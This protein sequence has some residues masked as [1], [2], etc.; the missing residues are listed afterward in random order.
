MILEIIA[1]IKR[2]VKILK[3]FAIVVVIF[4]VSW[5][6]GLFVW[7][8]YQPYDILAVTNNTKYA[9]EEPLRVRFENKT[10]KTFC[11]STR[12]PYYIEIKEGFR[13]KSY[14]YA[15]ISAEDV[16]LKCMKPG[17]TK[18]FELSLFGKE[19]V[20]RLVIPICLGCEMGDEFKEDRRIYST[21]FVVK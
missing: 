4:L 7:K 14:P 17:D 12:V 1:K 19:G 10:E 21:V 2:T 20:H 5:T 11:F 15:L 6:V 18:I 13:W 3:I 16:V 9:L 8:S